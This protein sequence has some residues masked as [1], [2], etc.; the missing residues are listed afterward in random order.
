MGGP[1]SHTPVPFSLFLCLTQDKGTGFLCQLLTENFFPQ[2][3]LVIHFRH[4]GRYKRRI[5]SFFGSI[6]KSI[7]EGKGCTI[8]S[9]DSRHLPGSD[10]AKLS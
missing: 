9:P 4:G 10:G 7:S 3:K 1:G 2:Q 6:A 8:G 5:A